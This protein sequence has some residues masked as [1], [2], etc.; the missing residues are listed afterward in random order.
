MKTMGSY[1]RQQR[2]ASNKNKQTNWPRNRYAT[3]RTRKQ[4][5]YHEQI[6]KIQICPENRRFCTQRGT[7]YF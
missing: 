3:L 6:S 4:F 7:V 5:Y 1:R 2:T